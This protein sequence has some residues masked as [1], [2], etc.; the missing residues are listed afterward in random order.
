MIA[1]SSWAVTAAL[2]CDPSPMQRAGDG[3]GRQPGS[4][5]NCAHF[6]LQLAR[7]LAALFGLLETKRAEFRIV[8]QTPR[9]RL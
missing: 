2:I 6:V 3:A 1:V 9:R 7:K 5:F 8:F 4:P